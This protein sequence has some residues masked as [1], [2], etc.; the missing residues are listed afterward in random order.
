MQLYLH[1][2]LPQ[3]TNTVRTPYLQFS[4]VLFPHQPADHLVH[5][6]AGENLSSL[7]GGMDYQLGSVENP[8]WSTFP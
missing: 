5:L 7:K 6:A 1:F 3:N 2:T 8:H 4:S